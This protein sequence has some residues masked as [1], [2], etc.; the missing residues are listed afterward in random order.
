MNSKAWLMTVRVLNILSS[1]LMFS[2]QIWFLID[3]FISDQ[4][5]MTIIIR[6]FVPI[7]VMYF[8]AK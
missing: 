5:F 7:F 8:A 6:L 2:F 3:L 1:A 4:E